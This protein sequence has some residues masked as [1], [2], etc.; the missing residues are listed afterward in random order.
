MFY[1]KIE[2]DKVI[3]A[4]SI[5]IRKGYRVF[6]YDAQSNEKMLL[7]DGYKAFDF[8]V[9]QAEIV[10]GKIVKKAAPVVEKNIFTKLEI[11]RACRALKL[12]NKLNALLAANSLFAADWQDASEID[13][14]DPVLL[15][16]LAA[17]TFTADEIKAIKEVLK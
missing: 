6:G 11:R 14:Q 8:P 7:E 9:S 3:Q 17:G 12:E 16:A 13:L 2:N 10:E 4:P 1:L 15:E 5:C